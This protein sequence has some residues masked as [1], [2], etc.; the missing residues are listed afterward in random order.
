MAGKTYIL[1]NNLAGNA[2]KR[3]TRLLW[4]KEYLADK[5]PIS[6]DVAAIESY[7]DFLSGLESEDLVYLCGGD[8]TINHLA[9]GKG[10]TKLPCDFYYY[11]A[12]TGNDFLND[13]E[14][15]TDSLPFCINEYLENLPSVNV[16]DN[17]YCFINNVGF[18]IDGYCSEVGDIQKKKSKKP[19]NYTLIALKGLAYGYKP[20]NATVIVDDRKYNFK[21]VWMAPTMKGRFYGGGMMAAPEQNRLDRDGKV[22][23]VVIHDI[24]KLHTLMLF[25]SIFKGGHIKYKK[26]VTILTGHNITVEFDRPAS[27]QVDGETIKNVTKYQVNT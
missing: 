11:S 22:S 4:L 18:G 24:G 21:K 13:L 17:H 25:P 1:H 9:N 14:K 10:N 2:K 7:R 27:V 15:E 19:V 8:G 5:N 16:N 3:Q 20:K 26:N 6:I 23:L 12:G